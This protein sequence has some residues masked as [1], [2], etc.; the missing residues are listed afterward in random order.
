MIKLVCLLFFVSFSVFA[1]DWHTTSFR[2]DGSFQYWVGISSEHPNEKFAL[3][4]AYQEALNEAAK[5]NFGFKHKVM[6]NTYA[7]KN[8]HQVHQET[9]WS[10]EKI[11]FKG[12]KPLRQVIKE[13][14]G[15]YI[16]YR[17]ISYPKM[18][19]KEELTRLSKYEKP[20]EPD[21]VTK[22]KSGHTYGSFSIKS[23]VSNL[24]V[25]LIKSDSPESK[26]IT[27]P[28]ELTLPTGLY[29]LTAVKEGYKPLTREVIITGGANF[30]H[31]ELETTLGTLH[32]K[33]TPLDAKIKVN[34]KIYSK[35]LIDLSAGQYT[36]EVS[37][38]DYLTMTEE[39][40]LLNGN[41]VY[42]EILLKPKKSSV[43]I[44]SSPSQAQVF[45]NGNK[46][47]ETPLV[48]HQIL[49]EEKQLNIVVIKEGYQ[50]SQQDFNYLPNKSLEPVNFKLK[51]LEK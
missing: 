16:A 18:A 27:A 25:S 33:A 37:H 13:K 23:N 15:K 46:A 1:D 28:A 36:I 21:S 29:Y 20:I 3:A 35:P 31:I 49:N 47:G 5:F 42:R 45:I 38:P 30:T 2:E 40:E 8:E 11:L 4:E 6:E 32:L 14:N 34:G 44:F 7:N 9:E 19:I 17:E 22:N 24:K 41:G 43:T 50:L 26:E 10:S 12:V 48:G 51:R 39:I